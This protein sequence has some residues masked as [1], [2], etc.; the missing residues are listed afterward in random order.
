MWFFLDI[1]ARQVYLEFCELGLLA[2]LIICLQ[3][4]FRPDNRNLSP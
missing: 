4:S 1:N 3:D 2:L